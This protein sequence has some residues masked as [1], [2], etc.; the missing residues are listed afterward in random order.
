MIKTILDVQGLNCPLPVLHTRKA[1]KT[2]P[3]GA[4]IEVR[5]TDPTSIQDFEAYCRS[6]GNGLLTW[7]N[8]DGIFIFEICKI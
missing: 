3:V 1:M 2:L 5:T 4:I 7:Q 6:T 8:E